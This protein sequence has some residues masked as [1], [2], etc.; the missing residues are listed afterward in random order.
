MVK[1]VSRMI[2]VSVLLLTTYV[3][4]AFAFDGHRKGFVLGGGL[5]GGVTVLKQTR[6]STVFSGLTSTLKLGYAPSDQIMLNY[7]GQQMWLGGNYFLGSIASPCLEATYYSSKASPSM[8]YGVG[9]GPAYLGAFGFGSIFQGTAVYMAIGRELQP[10]W[11]VELNLG[12][13]W[14]KHD[15]DLLE[16]RVLVTLLAY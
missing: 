2:M 14:L 12:Y 15:V 13:S 3:S 7:W 6:S 9:V 10:H 1:V 5:G 4:T 11:S 16:F 8:Y